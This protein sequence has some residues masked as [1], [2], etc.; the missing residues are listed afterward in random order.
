MQ[1]LPEITSPIKTLEEP[2]KPAFDQDAESLSWGSFVMEPNEDDF[3]K[4]YDM[5]L[6]TIDH[7]VNKYS[8]NS[9]VP[10]AAIQGQALI[11]F[12]KALKS[13]RPDKGAKLSSWIF[14]QMRPLQRFTRDN[15]DIAHI[16]DNRA[17]HIYKLRERTMFLT[18]KLGRE[19]STDELSE[20]LLLPL[21]TVS[22]LQKELKKDLSVEEGL[23]AFA[24]TEGSEQIEDNIAGMRMDL[25][26]HQ[27][28][29]LDH[30]FGLNGKTKLPI[31]G[32]AKKLN[33]PESR[34]RYEQKL[35]RDKYQEYFQHRD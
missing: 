31:K 26:G 29:I 22:Q 35:V 28:V 1:E 2:E 23:E 20:D 32:I 10:K 33:M 11:Q 8:A 25:P 27:Q 15:Q 17:M 30:I 6:T 34:V 18:D 13:F 14:S 16:P 4:L 24:D 9:N 12:D 7:A 5:H 3:G 21:K 19:P